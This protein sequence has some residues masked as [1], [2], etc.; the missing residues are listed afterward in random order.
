MLSAAE[1][2]RVFPRIG[3]VVDTVDVNAEVLKES[4]L[5]AVDQAVDG[6]GLA[7]GPGI[8]HHRRLA[9]VEDLLDHVQLAQPIVTIVD[10]VQCSQLLA[11]LVADVLYVTQPVVDKA[12]PVVAQ[13]GE[14]AAAS[15]M[16]ADDDVS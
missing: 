5:E 10:A 15:I 12:E 6:D 1:C 11:V 7:A 16:A 2:A 9:D 13:R 14:D 4:V 8:A 3:D